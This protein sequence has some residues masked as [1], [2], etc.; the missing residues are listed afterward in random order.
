LNPVAIIY[1]AQNLNDNFGFFAFSWVEKVWS[2]AY[3]GITYSPTNW[4]QLGIGIGLEQADQPWRLAY[5]IWAG[6]EKISLFN[7]L[8][9][10]G[11]GFYYRCQFNMR[12]AKQLGLGGFTERY[13]GM[14]PR[15]EIN[16]PGVPQLWITPLYAPETNQYNI[17]TG[18]TFN[19]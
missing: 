4:L 12:V 10:G 14:G 7:V 17:I 16:L 5:S 1:Q 9:T 18:L 6:N 15:V 13:T 8:E 11:S 19:W 3:G 2:E